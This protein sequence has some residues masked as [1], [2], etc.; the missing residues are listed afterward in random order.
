MVDSGPLHPQTV[1]DMKSRKKLRQVEQ[2]PPKPD[3]ILSKNL[4]RFPLSLHFLMERLAEGD[5]QVKM[6]AAYQ[7]LDRWQGDAERF[8]ELMWNS[9]LPEIQE[10]A[11]HLVSMHRFHQQAFPLLRVFQSS[12]G[13]LRMAAGEALG[14]L[15]YEPAVKPLQEWF[16]S[17]FMAPEAN[18]QELESA[19]KSLLRLDNWR[20][21]EEFYLRLEGC[22]Q[23]HSIYSVLFGT[24]A[25][26]TEAEEQVE[27]IAKA[28]GKARELFNDFHLSQYLVGVFGRPNLNR[29]L[30]SR[31][32]AGY[33]LPAIYQEAMQILGI[34]SETPE[35]GGIL[36][37]MAACGNSRAG[38]EAFLPL[39]GQLIDLV[40]PDLPE[41]A[42]AK[43]FLRGS[44]DWVKHWD[45]AV[46]KVREVEHPLLVS[47]PI[48]T[49][50]Y[51]VESECREDPVGQAHRIAGI[52]QSPLLS[53]PFMGEVLN[54][55]SSQESGPMVARLGGG[56]LS[57]WLRD[58]EKDA[59]WKL[60]THQLDNLDYPFE[61][62]LP[63]PWE[64]ENQVVMARL[65]ELLKRRF[66]QY[67]AGGR[68]QAVDYCLEVFRR[69]GSAELLDLLLEHF[70]DLIGHHYYGFTELINHLPDQRFLTPLMR[71][72]REDEF[73]LGRLIRFISDVHGIPYPQALRGTPEKQSA[74]KLHAT[75]RLRC[76]SC[77]FSYQYV[78]GGLYVDEERLEQRQIPAARDIWTPDPFICK[79]CGEEVPLEPEQQ[80]LNDLY[81]ELLASRLFH[82]TNKEESQLNHIHLIP[83]PTM[84]GKSC[85]PARFLKEVE[86]ALARCKEP[87]EQAPLLME[88]GRFN[89][90]IGELAR[91]KQ[92]FQSVQAGPVS[93]PLAI[94]Y[95][96]VIAF[97]EKNPYDARVHFSR[98]VAACGRDEFEGELDNPVD[99]AQHYM[100]LLEKREFK[101]SHFRLI[102][103]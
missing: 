41:S 91:A 13:S 63:Q 58:E 62:I 56:P 98:F 74:G 53:P 14:T 25:R 37:G 72:F 100:K 16:N 49:M 55:L 93:Q 15:H 28:Y 18:L 94:Y 83:F 77:H 7:L 44:A 85:H 78:L 75:V 38:L 97:Q 79:Q 45:E 1:I 89:L 90:E 51:L 40:A 48:S 50:L 71:Y 33:S 95:L 52:Y 68:G 3:P 39:A 86:G 4:G 43:A 103:S 6:W 59:L 29:Y 80:Y 76:P 21:W 96:G 27:R 101:R 65:V 11:V 67:L 73:E 99:M 32:N 82:V 84:E 31:L 57:G 102:S 10:S 34:D 26:H 61:Q 35:I 22:R 5:D 70:D 12:V 17:V 42:T 36:E 88:L 24:L 60:L 54:I 19:A 23:S 87:G 30:Q 47:L 81:S 46:L 8:I 64:F 69:H 92:A 2:I 20:Y 9:S 66:P